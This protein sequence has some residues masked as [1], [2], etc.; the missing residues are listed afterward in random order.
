MRFSERIGQREIKSS[1]QLDSM[2]KD[3]RVS[4]WNA[5]QV[6]YLDKVEIGLLGISN[7]DTFFRLLWEPPAKVTINEELVLSVGP[8]CCNL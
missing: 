5:F 1:I 4:L 3:I 8:S 6:F 2:D 7:F